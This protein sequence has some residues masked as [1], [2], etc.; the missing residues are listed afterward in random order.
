MFPQ[1]FE[2]GLIYS[3]WA[4]E[5]HSYSSAFVYELLRPLDLRQV[6]PPTL[7]ELTWS[8]GVLTQGFPF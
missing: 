1:Q 4:A 5:Y 2:D 3:Y 7:K 8:E 6:L